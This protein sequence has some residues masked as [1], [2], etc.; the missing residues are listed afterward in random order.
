[1]PAFHSRRAMAVMLAPP[2]IWAVHF[3]A[4]YVMVSL[5]CA[6]GASQQLVRTGIAVA[7][8]A[9]LVPI[10]VIALRSLRQWRATRGL[11]E[12]DAAPFFA[13]ATLMLCA[14]STLAL[15][16]VALPGFMLPPCVA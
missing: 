3:L 4:C 8:V 6:H 16:W 10:A 7:S 9:G 2:T 5:A 15:V 14:I 11:H 12:Q 1:M 13:V